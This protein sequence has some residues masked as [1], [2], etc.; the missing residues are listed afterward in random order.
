M[1]LIAKVEKATNNPFQNDVCHIS[2]LSNITLDPFLSQL[3]IQF[4]SKTAVNANVQ[5]VRFESYLD[6][7]DKIQD[8][9]LLVVL[10]NFEYQYPDWYCNFLSGKWTSEQIKNRVV[11]NCRYIYEKLKKIVSCPIVWFGYEVEGLYRTGVC[12][13]VAMG[14]NIID[15]INADIY[16]LLKENDTCIDTRHLIAKVGISNAYDNNNKYRWN[17]PYSYQMIRAISDEI[18]KQYLI[19][20]GITKKCIILDCD[21]VLW[22]GI[23]SED[24][25]GQI[26]LGNEGWGRPYQDFQRYLLT[27]YYYGVI[28]AICSKNDLQDV[29][30]V[31]HEHSGMILKEENIACFQVNWDNK[32]NN[33]RKI[34]ETLNIGLD[35]IVFVDDSQF[36]VE[37]I[38]TL[39]PDIMAVQYDRNTIYESLSCFNLKNNINLKQIADR[40]LTYQ[41]N[42]EREKLRSESANYES[43]L[44][45]LNMKVDIHRAVPSEA[46]RIAELTQR[47]NQCT[48]GARYT[49]S[50]ISE[51]LNNPR[52]RLY[53][54]YV[55]DKFGDLGLI[56]A[57]G[58]NDITLDLFSLSC[59]ALGRNVEDKMIKLIRDEKVVEYKFVSTGK[60]EALENLITINK[61]F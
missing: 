37:S 15:G 28:L 27:L 55:S 18:Y 19:Q 50:E 16:Y 7:V 24:G 41:S 57:V 30:Q 32:V 23:L 8:S 48:N 49:V 59:R 21:G 38:R 10:I 60:N 45:S 35:S 61:P 13:S 46:A 25:I 51:R 42:N 5:I 1:N 54:V 29:M 6:E 22:G 20:M 4:F 33:I 56:G 26:K 14:M 53:S 44:I 2:V 52:Y 39:F 11:E 17:M 34:A 58:I 36:E 12:G 40:N 31:F 9:D 3:L 43:Y 47:T